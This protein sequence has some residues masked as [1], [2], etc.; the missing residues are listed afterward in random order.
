MVTSGVG[1]DC[2]NLSL[3]NSW[4]VGSLLTQPIG[5]E[6]SRLLGRSDKG[7][8][9]FDGKIEA[10]AEVELTREVLENADE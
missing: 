4:L 8:N 1:P 5:L 6:S 7:L 2:S 10:S 3:G 9:S